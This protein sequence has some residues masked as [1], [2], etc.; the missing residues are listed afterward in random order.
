MTVLAEARRAP[1]PVPVTIITGFLGSGK[2]SLL[3]ALLRDSA[4]A[5]AVVL[6]NEFG[7]IGLDHLFVEKID[8]DMVMMASGCLC[9]TIRGDLIDSLENLLRRRDNGRMRDFDRV[10]IETTGLAD[11]APVLHTIMSHPYLLLRFRLNGVVTVVDAING[12]ATLDAYPEA[13]KQAAVADR[14]VLSK[15]DLIQS[16]Q[17]KQELA[18]LLARL[19]KLNPTARLLDNTKNWNAANL[20]DA[21]LFNPS[22]KSSDV[23]R[24][25]NAERL[26][27]EANK[28]EDGATASR[29]HDHAHEADS[30]LHP[31]A[32]A[33][34][35]GNRHE[36]SIRSFCLVSD[37][38]LPLS[39]CDLFLEMLR[40]AHGPNLLRVKG[41]IA[42]ADDPLRPLVI[43]GVQHV[44]HPPARL[45]GWP[46]SDHRTRI[47]F[48]VRDLSPHIIEGLYAAFSGQLRWDAPDAQA[49]AANPLKPRVGG[50]LS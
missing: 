49:L 13:L 48:I 33:K 30:H 41:V 10:I 16:E 27:D 50:L 3:N 1:P 22:T 38:P 28:S 36:E 9:C 39:A 7:E 24:W 46:D 8:G 15:T 42:L 47:V 44:F 37:V 31:S 35:G 18:R 34:A 6:I 25:L 43:H 17:Q 45:D 21:G 2:T 4:L 5:R 40:A 19:A 11:P 29:R 26:I 32:P 23:T 14:L 12:A 20:L